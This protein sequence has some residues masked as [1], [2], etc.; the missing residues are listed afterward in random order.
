MATDG[1]AD[2]TLQSA[3]L[4]RETVHRAE[5]SAAFKPTLTILMHPNSERVGDVFV[6][7]RGHE[8]APLE[9]SR[10]APDF[11]AP[12]TGSLMPIR[13]SYTSRQP[14]LIEWGDDGG[15]TLSASSSASDLAL[16]GRQ[17]DEPMHVT[18]KELHRG[19]VL[20]MGPHVAVL[21][22]RSSGMGAHRTT[23]G[24]VGESDAIQRIRQHIDRIAD[25]PTKVLIRGETG[26]GK[27]L[28]AKAIHEESERSAGPFIAVN[29][30]TLQEGTAASAL[31]GHAKG[32]FSGADRK[33]EGYFGAANGGTLFLDEIGETPR[34]VQLMLLRVLD[35]DGTSAEVQ[36]VGE[37]RSRLLDVRI[38][39]AT[40]SDLERDVQSGTFDN[41]LL[42][43]LG[44]YEIELP[45][46][47]ERL[48]DVGRLLVLFAREALEAAGEG[49][50]L[51]PTQSD[52]KPWLSPDTIAL[53]VGYDWPGN[54]R[55]LRNTVRQIAFHS[56]GR[57]EAVLDE[58]T[59][60]SLVTPS[61][62]PEA[63]N[64]PGPPQEV[65]VVA[66]APAR[67][68]RPS[69]LTK[70]EVIE[71]LAEADWRPSR[72]AKALQI[73]KTTFYT[74]LKRFG[75]KRAQDLEA[76]VI[77]A[78]LRSAGGDVGDAARAL[79]VGKLG[80]RQRMKVLHLEDGE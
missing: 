25:M 75:I 43:R 60:R 5:A 37:N 80:L 58:A 50:R 3:T 6:V 44:E 16:G 73:S 36:P 51:D 55:E 22:H 32:A 20:G 17:L 45:P 7:E 27:E 71:S 47:R 42:A 39:T 29:M 52:G 48:D 67:A 35:G 68:R 28:V 54:V 18:A 38:V 11:R 21:L 15:A 66:S 57:A 31:F 79:Q 1:D 69:T 24:L 77:D 72:A 12:R 9:V 63:E 2:H 4:H 14:L 53:L 59:R 40:D 74:L 62:G 49:H 8:G 34:Q 64:E 26:T 10:I 70:D 76:E 56:R 19:V 13:E 65:A 78:A 30:A 46:L 61:G 23:H 33:T 41:A